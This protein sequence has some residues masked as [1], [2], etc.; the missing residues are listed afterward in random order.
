M[1]GFE[2]ISVANASP[3]ILEVE[4]LRTHF[5]TDDGVMPAVDG[6]SFNVGRGRT[7]ALVGE[8]GSGKSVTSHSILRLI[9]PPGKI[10]GGRILLRSARLGDIDLAQLNERSPM[11][12]RVRGGLVSMIFQEPMTALSPVHTVGNQIC[13]AILL[14]QPVKAAAAKALAIDMLDKVGIPDPAHRFQQYPHELSGG[15]RQRVVIAMALVCRPELLIADEPTTALDVTVQAQVLGLIRSLQREI[16]CS[17]LLIT[18]DFGVVAQ[19]ADEVA[20]MNRGRLVEQGSVRAV[21]KNP[22]HAYTQA[23]LDALPSRRAAAR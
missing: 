1:S 4:D 6:V 14:H 12:Y 5:I 23:L 18:H 9:Q 22:Q 21:L 20:V 7:L 11:L 15:M 8:S 3:N 2:K 19:M 16:G 10:V 17:V 13:E